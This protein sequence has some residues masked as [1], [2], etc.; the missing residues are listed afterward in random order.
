[1]GHEKTI[2]KKMTSCWSVD[3]PNN[4]GLP[5]PAPEICLA[6]WN[7]IFLFLLVWFTSSQVWVSINQTLSS[8]EE[9]IGRAVEN[10]FPLNFWAQSCDPLPMNVTECHG[11]CW[12]VLLGFWLFWAY[13]IASQGHSIFS[14]IFVKRVLLTQWIPILDYVQVT[15]KLTSKRKVYNP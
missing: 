4:I 1:M 15:Q 9:Q 7:Q 10:S 11:K 13:I 14:Q 6:E 5:V 12:V 3:V 8:I 2:P